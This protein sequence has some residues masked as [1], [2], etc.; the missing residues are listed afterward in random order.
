MFPCQSPV[1]AEEEILLG[2]KY[3]LVKVPHRT[4]NSLVNKLGNKNVQTRNKRSAK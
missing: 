2:K 4:S 1:S 3:C